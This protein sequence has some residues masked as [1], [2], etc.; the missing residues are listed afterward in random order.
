MFQWLCPL[1]HVEGRSLL[2]LAHCKVTWV[3]E[4][5]YTELVFT[6][7]YIH[8]FVPLFFIFDL[9][10]LFVRLL[11]KTGSPLGAA[12]FVKKNR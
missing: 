2:I 1:E 8:V 5:S 11:M 6:T 12:F 3:S 9:F 4:F 7:P 10:C